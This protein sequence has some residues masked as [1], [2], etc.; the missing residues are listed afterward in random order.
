MN[1]SRMPKNL[2]CSAESFASEAQYLA[3]S[4]CGVVWATPVLQ[5]RSQ[6]LSIMHAACRLVESEVKAETCSLL[7]PTPSRLQS[8]NHKY[9]WSYPLSRKNPRSMDRFPVAYS[10]TR[11]C[12]G[13]N[14]ER[15]LTE[16][17]NSPRNQNDTPSLFSSDTSEVRYDHLTKRSWRG[18]RVLPNLEPQ[19]NTQTLSF[20]SSA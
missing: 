17:F 3:R 20:L 2:R 4:R 14:E 12:D 18:L 16:H 8:S 19:R 7:G 10:R 6:N 9:W 13:S 5:H 15:K 11:Q 1:A